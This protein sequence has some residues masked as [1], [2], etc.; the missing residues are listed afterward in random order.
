METSTVPVKIPLLNPN[1]PEAKL[2]SL[3]IV[4]G[5][6]VKGGDLLCTLETTKSTAE[7]TAERDGYVINLTFSEGELV[8]AGTRLC[9]L[10]ENKDWQPDV[11]HSEVQ[12]ETEG[13]TPA[14]IPSGLRISKPALMLAQ[15]SNLDL[16]AF[17][18]GPLV[19]ENYV[20]EIIDSS[21]ESA[22]PDFEFNP[23]ELI[24]YGGGGHGKSV[25]DLI[26]ATGVYRIRGVVDDGLEPGTSILGFEV[27]GGRGILPELREQG[28]WQ[29]VNAVGGI[30]DISSRLMVFQLLAENGFVCPALSHPSAVI[31]TSAHIAPGVQVFPHAYVGSEANVGFGVIV[32]TGA[33]VSHECKLDDYS[34]I[35]PGAILAGD[36]EIGQGSLI[37]MGVTVNLGVKIGENSK[38]G[39][40]ATVKSDVPAGG[41]VRAGAIWPNG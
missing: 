19:T 38:I 31:E 28:V 4:E 1:E 24:I 15:S 23:Q 32:N 16:N 5:Q 35:S 2:V 13:G 3:V 27:M 6:H 12:L 41:L 17:P 26:R 30:G 22:Q 37:G 11:E 36:V 20:R 14:D 10:S 8:K 39:N 29:A 34:N 21:I 33:I 25:I 40:S 7:L 18:V 9:Y